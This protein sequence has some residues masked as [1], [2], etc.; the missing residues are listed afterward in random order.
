[1]FSWK[2]GMR[3]DSKGIQ[4]EPLLVENP[5][6]DRVAPDNVSCM[7][8]IDVD[9]EYARF[10]RTGDPAAL[11]EVYDALAP[12]LL[13]VA[14]H[15]SRNGAAAEDLLQST[16]VTAIERA[17]SHEPGRSVKSWL[18][19][20]LAHHAKNARRRAERVPEPDR[21]PR[22][23]P[24]TPFAGAHGRELE[25]AL[26]R[27]LGDLP[28]AF[29][30]VL[31]LR[32]RHGLT[33]TQIAEALARPPGTVRS[34]LA[35]GLEQIRHA[36]PPSLAGVL[37]L[38]VLGVRPARG[39]GAVREAI[40]AR[41]VE[42]VSTTGVSISIPGGVI[43]MS[44]V[45]SSV[46]VAGVLIGVAAL[47]MLIPRAPEAQP[48]VED[49]TASLHSE[50][51]VAE[52]APSV[53]SE[54]VTPIDSEDDSFPP[55]ASSPVTAATSGRLELKLT[56]SD[57]ASPASS[58]V[59][60]VRSTNS[61]LPYPDEREVVSNA[62]GCAVVEDLAP[63]PIRATALAGG[64]TS[65]EI[66]AG[67]TTVLYLEIPAGARVEGEV[68]DS[69]GIGVAGARI[70]LSE[71]HMAWR[72]RI[73]ATA[74]ERGRFE[75]RS[76]GAGR[77]IGAR[78]AGHAFSY[79]Q[80][81]DSPAGSTQRV[82]IVLDRI[83]AT[84]HGR[85]SV[86]SGAAVTGAQVLIGWERERY[87]H[88]LENGL[89][90]P[91]GAPQL[92]VTDTNGEFV[93]EGVLPGRCPVQARAPGLGSVREW[94]DVAEGTN[95]LRLELHP[96]ASLFGVVSDEEGDPVPCA[97]L[98]AQSTAIAAH[99]L[100]ANR[101]SM[102][103]VLTDPSSF[104]TMVSL[105]DA[106]GRFDLRGLPSGEVAVHATAGRARSARETLRLYA[107][108]RR[109]WAPRLETVPFVAGRVIDERGRPLSGWGLNAA[110]EANPIEAGR[111]TSTDDRGAFSIEV[112]PGRAHRLTVFEP[113]G[114]GRYPRLVR[115]GA[116]AGD[117]HLI[118]EVK[119][120][121][122]ATGV[123]IGSV[124]GPTDEPAPEAKLILWHEERRLWRTFDVD[125]KTGSFEIA[126]VPPGTLGI[127]VRAKDRPWLGLGR[128][129]IAAGARVDLG[130]V[131]LTEGSRLKATIVEGPDERLESAQISVP[132]SDNRLAGAMT[133]NGRTLVSGP[134]A[135]GKYTLAIRA[136]GL[137]DE[138]VEFEIGTSE[139]AERDLV[140]RPAGTRRVV[141]DV[142]ET[143]AAPQ[144]VGCLVIGPLGRAVCVR[145][146]Q[147]HPD[148]R[149]EMVVSI[150]PGSH[151][152]RAITEAGLSAETRVVQEG[153]G[154]E[155]DVSLRLG[156]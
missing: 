21:I 156:Y 28:E 38:G 5:G 105:A 6:V 107:G 93:L 31:I 41:A 66:R 36:L 123:V 109:P 144:W 96:E 134:L 84:V 147:V 139:D 68:V 18:V 140:L 125:P 91:S 83:G 99:P 71:R 80:P 3:R 152:V 2:A 22:A 67:E 62:E 111:A 85:V 39:L 128:R 58:V 29:R 47:W 24:E 33:T 148:R 103:G 116:R 142:A 127:D 57:G 30:P 32:L 81:I 7:R 43:A 63:G 59:S 50:T 119:D 23:S 86:R 16:F 78:G 49:R 151:V 64:Q 70:W 95:E 102:D 53:P 114:W 42:L 44:K 8:P 115:E 135:P 77:W 88:Q 137:L 104:G 65:G 14:L 154:R 130:V 17:G 1:M 11:G 138:V 106:E 92:A 101:A 46:I 69:Q 54:A 145:S 35:R 110:P 20:I 132:G 131:R 27:A 143:A 12:E 76:V 4:R 10:A 56:Y 55:P 73:V 90:V 89:F 120:D 126:H 79:L 97:M 45:A 136:D 112:S 146:Q 117:E 94:L 87:G 9:R 122:D 129:E 100:S 113:D 149:A 121:G 124:R 40:L 155:G 150:P 48:L 25:E 118:L 52:T 19:G 72:G 133:R 82:R 75:L 60:I 37:A 153:L 15:F 26:D 98:C 51:F 34:Q 108:E 13:R 141:V 61:P 74:D